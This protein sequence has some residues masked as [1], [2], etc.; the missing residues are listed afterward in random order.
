MKP[1][2]TF[3]VM[4]YKESPY[5]ENCI[6]SVLN[7]SVPTNVVIA[8]STPN[9]YIES[10]AQK[11]NLGLHVNPN[12]IGLGNDFDFAMN[13]VDTD[14]VTIAH[15]DDIYDYHYARKI[16]EAYEKNEVNDPIIVFSDYY[17]I[18]KGKR[19]YSG[20]NLVIKR[21]L[22]FPLRKQN[23]GSYQFFRR[24]VIRFGSAIC[25]PA[26]TFVKKNLTFPVFDTPFECDVDWNAW[27]QLSKKEHC[28]VFINEPLMGH[29]VHAAS[30]TTELIGNNVRHEEDYEMFCK[31]W[32]KPVARILAKAYS[33][34]EKQN[35]T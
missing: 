8:T 14:L 31:F 27:E 9:S 30:T 16:I 3:V 33:Q 7:Q 15:Q 20:V 2:H 11:Y 29:R 10:M 17:E 1:T 4:A 5:L 22:L 6:Q 28:F 26:V 25:C 19:F 12:R 24:W 23:M 21:I 32:P 18:R 13:C 34:S 35:Q